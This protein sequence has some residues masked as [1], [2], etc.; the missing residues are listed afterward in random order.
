MRGAGDKAPRKQ[1]RIGVKNHGLKTC[2]TLGDEI[3]ISSDGKVFKQTLYRNGAAAPPAPGTFEKP[4]TDS[5]AP[6]TGCRIAIPY[7]SKPL[8]TPV[9]E[10]FEFPVPDKQTIEDI[11]RKACAEIPQ[12]FIGVIRPRILE[13]YTIE[14]RHH[15]LGVKMFT[16][17][18]TPARAVRGG[19]VFTRSCEERGDNHELL[20]SLREGAF[21]FTVP[22]IADSA[23]EIQAFTKSMADSHPKLLGD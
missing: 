13:T 11:F 7:R 15:S 14:L 18:C 3:A 9:G 10:R 17:R 21:V 16:F 19:R 6:M 20:S 22:L 5:S 4:I 23:R 12:R 1:H 2:F 8:T